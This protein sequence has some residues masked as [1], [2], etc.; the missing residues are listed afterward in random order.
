MCRFVEV[1]ILS[2]VAAVRS[3]VSIQGVTEFVLY[4]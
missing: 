2:T 1:L 4:A 3:R